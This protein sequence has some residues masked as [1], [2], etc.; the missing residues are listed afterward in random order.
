MIT[1]EQLA[2]VRLFRSE[3]VGAVTF[4]SLIAHFKTA[5][6]ALDNLPD[7]ARRGGRLRPL[8][9]CSE[10][11]AGREIE[12]LEKAGARLVFSDTPEYSRLLAALPDAPPFL[13]VWGNP[14]LLNGKNIAVVGTR[15]ASVNGKNIAR[16]MSADFVAAGYNVVSGL[17]IGIDVAAHEGAL[18][19]A[20]DK[21]ST[22]AVL[23]T[24]LNIPYPAQN[25]RFYD[26]IREKGLLVSEFPI[27]TKPQPSNFPYRNRIISGLSAALVVIEAALRSGSLITANKALEQGREVFAVPASPTDE[28]ASGVNHLIKTGAPLVESAQDVIAA[29]T[30]NPILG[31]SETEHSVPAPIKNKS[32]SDV[33]ATALSCADFLEKMDGTPIGIDEL[34]RETG[35]PAAAISVL[36]VE[37]ELAGRIERLPGGKVIRIMNPVG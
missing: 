15:N 8:K 18:Y 36:L 14:A 25:R 1:A 28:R 3:N 17:A 33:D 4:R 26:E 27:D 29:L 21:A 35:L 16:R 10:D 37:L 32:E 6:N 22:I 5:Q 12:R 9:I 30:E 24:G 34:V 23:G 20:T 13:S 31:L 19:A 2:K 11:E 7:C